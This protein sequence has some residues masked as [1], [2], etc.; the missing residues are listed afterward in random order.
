MP[1]KLPFG[2]RRQSFPADLWTQCPGCGE[3]LYN[4]QLDKTRR[5]CPRCGHHLRLRVDARLA[6]LLDRDSFEERDANL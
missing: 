3:M 6:L 1:I 2:P 4:K 5:V